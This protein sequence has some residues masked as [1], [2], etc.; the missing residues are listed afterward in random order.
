MAAGTPA[1]LKDSDGGV[2]R[3]GG[4]EGA[5]LEAAYGEHVGRHVG[6]AGVVNVDA[7]EDGLGAGQ[8]LVADYLVNDGRRE[9]GRFGG[10]TFWGWRR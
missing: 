1:G 9:S 6:V 7:G 3:G 2:A 8:G 10:C 4:L 5:E